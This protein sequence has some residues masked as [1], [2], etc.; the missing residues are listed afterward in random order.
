MANTINT[1]SP[2][3]LDPSLLATSMNLKAG[4][5]VSVDASTG[6]ST[7]SKPLPPWQLTRTATPD[8][9]SSLVRNVLTGG[10]FITS[11]TAQL[12][13]PVSDKTSAANYK[14]LF[15]LYQGLTALNGIATLAAGKN[16]SSYDQDRYQKAFQSGMKELQA[17]LGQEPFKGFDVTQGQVSTSIKSTIGATAETDVYTTSTVYSGTVN[18][19]VPA[20]QGDVRFGADVAKGGTTLHVDFD[21][22]EMDPATPRTMGNV[23]NYMNGKLHDAGISTRFAVKRTP[24]APQSVKV[25]DSTVKLSPSLDS[26]ALQVKG[27]AVEK[28]TLIPVA[29]TPAIY[30]AQKSGSTAGVSPDAQQQLLKFDAGSNAT[31]AKAGDGLTFQRALDA[32][33][34]TAKAVAT[35]PD[36]SVYILGSVSG[37]VA[38]QTIQGTSDLAL[39]K[40][41]SAGNLL[42]TRTLGAE[43]AA[44]GLALAVSADG[45]QV[46]VAGTVKGALDSTDGKVDAKTT[47][48]VVTV[49]D[50][51][52]QELWTQ[53]AGAAT[54]DD[55]PASVAF[56]SDGKVY[57][58]GQTSGALTGGGGK[59]GSTDGFI[60]VFSAT[61]KPLY[62]G[63]GSFAYTPKLASTVQY[64][65]SSV[66]RNAGIA[67]SG[68]NLYVAG[69]E[70]GRAVVRLYD[71]SSGKPTLS[72][73]RDLGDLQGGDVAGLTLQ[74]DGSVIVAG[75]T[76]NGALG[77]GTVTKAYGGTTKAAF[78]A[79]LSADLQPSSAETLA[80]VGGAT[81]QTAT[82][83]TVSAGKVFLT[84]TVSTGSKA[85]GKDVVPM[86]QGFVTEMD[87]AT[88]QAVWSRQYDGRNGVAAPTGIAVS[89]QGSSIL[90]KLGLP[91]GKVDFKTSDQVV[92]NTSVRPGDAFY[93]RSGQGGAAKLVTIAANDTYKTLATKISRALGFQAT[94]STQTVSGVTQLLIKPLNARTQIQIQ[95]GPQGRDA[96]TSLGITEAL[97]TTDAITAKSTAPG[98]QKNG[99]LAATNKLKGYYA[100]GLPASLNLS[101]SNDI[102]QAQSALQLALSTVRNVYSDM[103]TAPADPSSSAGSAPKYLTD[104][105]AQY[106]AALSRLTGGG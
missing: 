35:G 38:H 31:A 14:N 65:T 13:S 92:A 37:T 90:D 5:G 50:S 64:G 91:S 9:I 56:G 95:A 69:V 105:I 51:T 104:R 34:S 22:S 47:D 86:S 32:N 99:A 11:D 33:L 73:T 39:M 25:G 60:Q 53:R 106:Q 57:V 77:V 28:M 62:D 12:T 75:S 48:T 97:V 23:V 84:G 15:S 80:Y 7:A 103:T 46:A 30:V 100:L 72:Q 71:I 36:G 1:F 21:L 61:K 58:S 89:S 94:V 49:M 18:G 29:S 40:Y 55:Q 93:V 4:V 81:D 78:V 66:D 17:Y 44:Q 8:A 63:A 43:D 76:H 98:S 67:V 59:L 54:A 96:L 19:E 26:F 41:D 2:I 79:S 68:N 3:S 42:F 27:N 52:G 102:K 101:S 88:G 20:F 70:N 45:S 87:P 6:S 10:K 24:G 74:P 85:L 16:V 82:G 83:V